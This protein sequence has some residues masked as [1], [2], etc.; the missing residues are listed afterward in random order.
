M[1]VGY[2]VLSR[3]LGFSLVACE[4]KIWLEVRPIWLIDD[5]NCDEPV[6]IVFDRNVCCGIVATT[7]HSITL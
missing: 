3:L 2:V 7:G 4:R 1:V 5:I 6:T